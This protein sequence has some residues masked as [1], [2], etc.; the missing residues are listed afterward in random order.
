[1]GTCGGV[2]GWKLLNVLAF[3][4]SCLNHVPIMICTGELH[5]F[6][7]FESVSYF[8]G[9]QLLYMKSTFL[10]CTVI[11]VTGEGAYEYAAFWKHFP[12]PDAHERKLVHVVSFFQCLSV[13]VFHFS[14]VTQCMT[15]AHKICLGEL[16]HGLSERG[17]CPMFRKHF[18]PNE[19]A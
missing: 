9:L 13:S 18:Q 6:S 12:W 3:S 5:F 8:D 10:N 7:F 16:N 14:L 15:M 2:Q 17:A 19:H 1:V 4:S 11:W